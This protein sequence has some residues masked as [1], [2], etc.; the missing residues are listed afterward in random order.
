MPYTY[1]GMPSTH[2]TPVCKKKKRNYNECT[3]AFLESVK[4]YTLTKSPQYRLQNFKSYSA[5]PGCFYIM[6]ML[7]SQL[8]L[9]LFNHDCI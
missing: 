2:I 8:K 5:V 3:R 4:I 1:T 6:R 9:D 7:E